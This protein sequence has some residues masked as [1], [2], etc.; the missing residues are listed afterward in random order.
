ML[1]LK[2]RPLLVE[3]SSGLRPKLRTGSTRPISART[4]RS[5]LL[6]RSLSHP[7]LQIPRQKPMEQMLSRLAPHRQPSRAVRPRMQPALHRLA[8]AHVFVIHAFAHGDALA[9]ALGCRLAHVVEVKVE[10]HGAAVNA[11]GQN[12]VGVHVSP[13]K[14]DHE[15]GI[16]PEVPCAIALA[17]CRGRRIDSRRNHR[18][19]L[20]AITI[21]VLDGVLLVLQHAVER[22]VQMRHVVTAVEIVIDEHLPVAAHRVHATFEKMHRRKIEWREPCCESAQEVGQRR[23]IGIEVDEDKLHPR[24]TLHLKLS[25]L[26]AIEATD[27]LK[28]RSAFQRSVEAVAPSVIGAAENRG[29][30]FGLGDDRGGMMTANVVKRAKLTVGGAH[31]YQRLARELRGYKLSGALQLV[32]PGNDLPRSAEDILALKARDPVIDVPRSRYGVGL[33][34][35]ALIVIG[36]QNVAQRQLHRTSPACSRE[37]MITG[38]SPSS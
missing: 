32:N 7:P 14:I 12:E 10:D 19:R 37:V 28:L 21:L 5:C 8:D 27:A 24:L 17:S 15:V 3:G 9:I 34:E 26:S 33:C 16:L 1:I 4:V 6:C 29:I 23:G 30:A 31:D 13:V 18:T 22:L 20:Q 35:W 2:G 36:K 25:V 38:A 11:I